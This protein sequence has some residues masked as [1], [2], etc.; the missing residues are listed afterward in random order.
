MYD[1]EYIG[2]LT[3]CLKGVGSG[4]H[5]RFSSVDEVAD[6]MVHYFVNVSEKCVPL[7]VT[8]KRSAEGS[9]KGQKTSHKKEER[10]VYMPWTLH[11]LMVDMRMGYV[12]ADFRKK[13]NK[14]FLERLGEDE[15]QKFI[16]LCNVAE[17]TC[18]NQQVVGAMIGIYKESIVAR[19]NGI[20]EKTEQVVNVVDKEKAVNDFLEKIRAKK[21]EKERGL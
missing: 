6:A 18:K 8:D 14:I 21:R 17:E 16:D 2:K 3:E 12:W 10:K 9:D 11:D 13:Y 20:V 15:Q 5:C 19:L 1:K 4:R 7:R